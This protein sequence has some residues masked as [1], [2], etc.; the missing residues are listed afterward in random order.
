MCTFIL[1]TLILKFHKLIVKRFLYLEKFGKSCFRWRQNS[2]F[3]FSS[4]VTIFATLTCIF[5]LNSILSQIFGRFGARKSASLPARRLFN[6]NGVRNLE[7]IF[8]HFW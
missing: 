4:N 3:C 2:T 7:S 6:Q 5:L 8:I 1:L